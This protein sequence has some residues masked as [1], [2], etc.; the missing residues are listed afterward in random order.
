MVRL[1]WNSKFRKTGFM[2]K[3][4]RPFLDWRFSDQ[5]SFVSMHL[6]LESCMG[7][8]F[9]THIR[10]LHQNTFKTAAKTRSV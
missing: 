3:N 2:G 6:E 10:L 5:G 7:V 9:V 8:I 1:I 4:K